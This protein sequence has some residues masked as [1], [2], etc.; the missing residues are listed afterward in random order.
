MEELDQ[1]LAEVDFLDQ[2]ISEAQGKL[3]DFHLFK[4]WLKTV[5]N[6]PNAELLETL[7]P[8]AQAVLDFK[9]AHAPT[10]I[11]HFNATLAALNV[12]NPNPKP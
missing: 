3:N 4:E 5:V 10:Y 2:A 12:L 8:D 6:P 11:A 1:L 7:F 9:A